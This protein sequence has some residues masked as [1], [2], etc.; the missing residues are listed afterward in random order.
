MQKERVSV[1]VQEKK[2]CDSTLLRTAFCTD[3]LD[4]ISS[5]I[6]NL[7]SWLMTGCLKIL[8]MSEVT[9]DLGKK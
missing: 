6:H 9:S 2:V 3:P 4:G 1:R 7:L 5:V 8:Y